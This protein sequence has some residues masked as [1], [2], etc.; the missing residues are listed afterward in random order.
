MFDLLEDPTLKCSKAGI[1]SSSVQPVTA[2]LGRC[3]FEGLGLELL[4]FFFNFIFIYF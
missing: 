3:S 4:Y 2:W 1:C